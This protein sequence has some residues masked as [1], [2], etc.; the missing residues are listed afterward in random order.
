MLFTNW[1]RIMELF[2]IQTV[3]KQFIYIR[4]KEREIMGM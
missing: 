3:M 1:Q 4:E 2:P